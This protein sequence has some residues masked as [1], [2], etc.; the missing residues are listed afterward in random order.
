MVGDSWDVDFTFL[1]G[2]ETISVDGGYQSFVHDG[3]G[4]DATMEIPEAPLDYG[5]M[6]IV[7]EGGVSYQ[8]FSERWAGNL[9]ATITPGNGFVGESYAV[10]F[11]A[12]VVPAPGVMTMLALAGIAGG[13]RRD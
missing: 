7:F 13:R 8:P 1:L 3:F 11:V 10:D 2:G 4:I 9:T 5:P 12:Q 6:T